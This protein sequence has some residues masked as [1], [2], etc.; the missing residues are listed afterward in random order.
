MPALVALVHRGRPCGSRDLTIQSVAVEEVHAA[1]GLNVR[2]DL[3]FFSLRRNNCHERISS[4]PRC[5]GDF[6]KF[7]ANSAT[8]RT[9]HST[10]DGA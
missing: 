5:S 6:L 2:R 9:Q 10:V 8:A 4:G 1:N 7:W 3:T